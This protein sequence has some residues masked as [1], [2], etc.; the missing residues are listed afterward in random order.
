M[1]IPT[2]LDAAVSRGNLELARTLVGR[3]ALITEITLNAAVW[4]SLRTNNSKLLRNFLDL[5]QRS[6]ADWPFP[7]GLGCTAVY[8]AV[9]LQRHDITGM[10][11]RSRVDPRGRPQSTTDVGWYHARFGRFKQNS[12]TFYRELD[13]WWIR[14]G[15][16]IDSSDSV[17]ERVACTGDSALV[18]MLLRAVKWRRGS[19]GRALITA[20]QYCQ[21]RFARYFLQAGAA[22]DQ[23]YRD[24]T[25]L[26]AAVAGQQVQLVRDL[27]KAGA[28]VNQPSCGAYG[29]T[30]L[31][32]AVEIAHLELVDMLLNANGDVN[33]PA[34]VDGGATALQIAAIQGHVGL[35]SR[36]LDLGADPNAAKAVKRGRTALEGAAESGR[37]DML[38]LLLTRGTRT[39]GPDRRHYV[40]AVHLAERNGHFA[41]A[42]YLRSRD[43]WTESDTSF[44]AKLV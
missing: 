24:S 12:E 40:S 35:A 13:H 14:D 20:V 23:E 15:E 8:M 3:G 36:L 41:A 38:H 11:L 9:R 43:G 44:Y 26:A 22:L 32:R 2:P 19:T 27:L 34:A 33:A 29:R 18:Q 16:L 30:A 7:E 42:N 6:S 5:F 28:N 39:G 25:V 4:E 37:I 17:L 10:L 21:F 1:A 31:Q